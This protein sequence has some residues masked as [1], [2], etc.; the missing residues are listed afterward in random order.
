MATIEK[1]YWVFIDI[2]SFDDQCGIGN[3]GRILPFDRNRRK[4]LFP[5]K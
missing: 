4:T 3:C 2:K 1:W 5:E